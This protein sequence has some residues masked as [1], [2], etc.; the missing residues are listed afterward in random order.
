[1]DAVQKRAITRNRDFVA[2]T[3]CRRR[4]LKCDRQLPCSSCQRRHDET[5]C[6]YQQSNSRRD[7]GPDDRVRA[8]ARLD[9]L[10]KL[11]EQ[12]SRQTNGASHPQTLSEPTY[13]PNLVETVGA[14]T[15]LSNSL[16]YNGSSHWSA[17]LEDIQGLKSVISNDT[18]DTTDDDISEAEENAEISLLFGA[19]VPLP[20][21]RILSQ[22]LPSRQE[23]DRLTAAYFRSK[24][25]SVPFIH[26]VQFRRLY[27][28]FWADPL[29]APLLWTSLLFSIFHVAHNTLSLGKDNLL[30]D[31][32]YVVAAAQCLALGEYFRPKRWAI[33]SLLLFLQA[34]CLTSLGTLPDV[35]IL[36]GLL[37]RL[38]TI[39]GYHR[40]PDILRLSAFEREM[41]RRTWSYCMQLDLLISFQL[42]LPS[43]IQ[44]PTWDT[45][46]PRNLHDFDFDEETK[47][48]PPSRA[49]TEPTDIQFY[50]A[51]H[52]LMA[53]FEKILRHTLTQ[54]MDVSTDVN[55]LDDEIHRVYF[56]L[57]DCFSP[58]PM[59]ASVV[60]SPSLIVTRLCVFF[61][62]QKSLCVLH[63]PYILRGRSHSL[64]I[65][66]DA[67]S[68]IVQH[69]VDVYKEFLPGG[70]LETER[71]FMGGITWHDY[72][73]AVM[74]LCLVLCTSAQDGSWPET[75]DLAEIV[76]LLRRARDICKEQATRSTDSER[77]R[78]VVDATLLR[79]EGGDL[80]SIDST[81]KANQL[82]A[83]PFTEAPFIIDQTDTSYV[84][85]SL[86]M[87]D[88]WSGQ[89]V[90][91]ATENDL[92]TNSLADPSW[93]YLEQF[94][95]L[96]DDEML[97]SL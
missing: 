59:A 58:R 40:D 74:L 26:T 43:N 12:V 39:M 31:N 19:A 52:R 82:A 97:G 75:T 76:Q 83:S 5:S 38:A 55:K 61:V 1:M 51:K 93:V 94:L 65:C 86:A 62:Y 24:G 27:E 6:Q 63:R 41:R 56:A 71:W 85:A 25:A 20:L 32:R 67:A 95:N 88:C 17:M 92:L 7:R 33:E 13:S 22:Y 2:C 29:N 16:V 54:R 21:E 3:E 81:S 37:V 90:G 48:L 30:S 64:S 73:L 44:Y 91:T 10:E 77:V 9:H 89:A 78:R 96:P 45:R 35:G 11:V 42:G 66:R 80:T 72:L 46:P 8:E 84:N 70:Q 23:S 60:D 50:I 4:K 68:K 87:Q 69:Y 79:F 57:P 28:S 34:K 36:L 18:S 47:Q 14:K 53:V 49:D 15:P